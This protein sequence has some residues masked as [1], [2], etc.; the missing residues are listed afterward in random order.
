MNTENIFDGIFQIKEPERAEFVEQK[1]ETF[2]EHGFHQ[3]SQ[4][5]G[6][7]PGLKVCLQKIFFDFKKRARLGEISQK[8]PSVIKLEE[9][10][11][12]IDRWENRVKKISDE[13]IPDLRKRIEIL[14]EEKVNIRNNPG[15]ILDEPT[16]KASFYIGC[17]ILLFVSI[18][19]FVFYSSASYSA[20]F[21][22]FEVTEVGL[23]DS[24]FDAQALGKAWHAG[25]TELIF[26][27]T[28]PFV[29][30]GLGYLMHKVQAKTKVLGRQRLAGLIGV[31]FIFD[32][33]LAYSITKKIHDI[34]NEGN[35]EYT[36]IFTLGDAFSEIDFW[37][38]IFAGFVV[39]LIWGFIFDLV[40]EAYGKLDKV[41]MAL[42]ERDRKIQAA[43]AE[44]TELNTQIEKLI[45][46]I[47]DAKTEMRKLN[48]IVDSEIPDEEFEQHI[49]HFATG[50]LEW[51]KANRKADTELAEANMV[52]EE[53][54]KI[55]VY[56]PIIINSK[57]EISNTA[58]PG[59]RLP[60]QQ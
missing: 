45:H 25:T 21:K 20:F 53:F 16:D 59:S 40:I 49:Y 2:Q 41:K 9:Y 7:I 58:V 38:I 36:G 35:P 19:L 44:I 17:F 15:E 47:D 48:K 34:I 37:M 30:L 13:L 42:L 5:G 4:L 56:Q 23:V 32:S 18:Y 54:V 22:I 50:W 57:H 33:I 10:R 60:G 11:G 28:I 8:K 12:N 6:T 26:I 3:S 14:T 31:S 46:S 29:F 1:I 27:L 52:V 24:I 51:M 39:Y 43:R 55:T